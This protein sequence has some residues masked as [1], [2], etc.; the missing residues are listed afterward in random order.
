MKGI[1]HT[2]PKPVTEIYYDTLVYRAGFL[3]DDGFT[4]SLFVKDEKQCGSFFLSL[5]FLAFALRSDRK[6]FWADNVLS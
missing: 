2:L 1:F 3:D 4:E 5:S 6:K